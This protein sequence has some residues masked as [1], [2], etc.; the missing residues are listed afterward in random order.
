M[1]P[2]NFSDKRMKRFQLSEAPFDNA[3]KVFFTVILRIVELLEWT[4]T[5]LVSL[6]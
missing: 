3:A 6:P 1:V 4:T 5:F 2:S